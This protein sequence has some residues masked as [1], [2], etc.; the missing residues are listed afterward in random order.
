[1]ELN[2][3]VDVS[4]DSMYDW[5]GIKRKVGEAYITNDETFR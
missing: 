4:F 3:D 1:M 2:M 5:K